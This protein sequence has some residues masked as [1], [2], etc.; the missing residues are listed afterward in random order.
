MAECYLCGQAENIIAYDNS[1]NATFPANVTA[2]EFI[3]DLNG[4]ASTATNS[5]SASKAGAVID[6]GNSNKTIQIGWTG[7]S[8]TS[9]NFE[10]IAGYSKTGNIKDVSWDT[11][12][13]KVVPAKSLGIAD[14]NNT[15]NVVK[16][17]WAGDSLDSSTLWKL[18][19]YTEDGKIKEASWD[20]VNQTVVPQKS[21]SVVDYT[22]STKTIQ[23]GWQGD[24]LSS[25]DTKY[26]AVYSI[27]GNIKDTT[28]DTFRDKLSL[29]PRFQL[30]DGTTLL[31]TNYELAIN[32]SSSR[33]GGSI[34]YGTWTPSI[35]KAASYEYRYGSWI[36]LGDVV[37]LSF[38]IKVT[39]ETIPSGTAVQ[40]RILGC[41]FTPV[42][43]YSAGGGTLSGYYASDNLV[44]SGYVIDK[45]DSNAIYAVAQWATAAGYKY[46]TS[47]SIG[48]GSQ[49]IASGTIQFISND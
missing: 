43:Q 26:P 8:L 35:A 23:I 38:S 1:K 47:C 10:Y 3:G 12:N 14:Y 42:S 22:D 13:N 36:K 45:S 41:P 16:V 30:M 49:H 5:D 7:D 46:T 29:S 44:F 24:S 19:G 28:W 39:A 33:A 15:E 32:P 9:D 20:A 2:S 37:T 27:A 40:F 18:A 11:V 6:N 34:R 21:S 31:P 25:S 4:N 48:S 17:G